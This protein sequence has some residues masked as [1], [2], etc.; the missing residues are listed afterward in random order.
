MT[1]PGSL[2][3]G[4]W[5]KQHLGSR[6][7]DEHIPAG[8]LLRFSVC[9]FSSVSCPLAAVDSG[10]VAP[11]LQIPQLAGILLLLKARS[12]FNQESMGFSQSNVHAQDFQCSTLL[13][14][15]KKELGIINRSNTKILATF[16]NLTCGCSLSN[17]ASGAFLGFAERCLPFE[18]LEKA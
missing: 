11:G 9:F 14:A 17:G 18:G 10:S 7:G 8:G 2:Q 4:R 13:R 3:N 15:I 16:P 1:L 6:D 12:Q 5:K